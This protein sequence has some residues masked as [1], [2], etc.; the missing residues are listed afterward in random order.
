MGKHI[1]VKPASNIMKLIIGTFTK[2]KVNGKLTKMTEA[3][4]SATAA[5]FANRVLKSNGL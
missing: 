3:I 1:I 5:I 4:F 2:M